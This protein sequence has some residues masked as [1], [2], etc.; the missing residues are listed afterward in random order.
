MTG[1]A[2]D[3]VIFH[4]CVSAFK[5]GKMKSSCAE[6]AFVSVAAAAA[7]TTTTSY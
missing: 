5:Q 6:P 7:T 3:I 4:T 1:E 2:N